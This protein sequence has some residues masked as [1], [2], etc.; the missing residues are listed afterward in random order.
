MKLFSLIPAA[1]LAAAIP[2]LTT[3]ASAEEIVKT[4]PVNGHAKLRVTTDDGS[5]R[6]STGDIHQIEVRIVYSGYKL[7]RDL[8]VSATQNAD[9]VD[10]EAKTSSGGFFSFGVRHSSLR[11]E[12]HMPKDADLEAVAGDGSIEA[13][14]VTGSIDA[15]AGDG[16][17]TIQGGKG[18]VRLHTGDGHIDAR[19]LDGNVDASSGDGSIHLEGRFDV[20][21]TRSGDGSVEVRAL[22]GSRVAATWNLKAGDGSIDVEIPGDMQA[23]IDASTHDGH[24]SLGIPVTVE[25]SFSSSRIN[26]KMNGGGQSIVVRTGDGSIHLNK[27]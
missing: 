25:G 11:V 13:D 5:I 6:V 2:L 20:V 3:P 9:T 24:I 17:I 15:R 22:P 4:F 18:N 7:D 19:N 8:R 16:S 12:I 23:T 10:V 1:I 27:S 26:G 21:N 14:G